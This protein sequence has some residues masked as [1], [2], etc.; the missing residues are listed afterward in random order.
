MLSHYTSS[1]NLMKAKLS[2]TSLPYIIYFLT[3]LI[4]FV[5][6]VLTMNSNANKEPKGKK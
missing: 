5:E 3:S 2:S 6:A 4:I 1:L